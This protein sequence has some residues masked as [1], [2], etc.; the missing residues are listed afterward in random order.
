MTGSLPRD[1]VEFN[2]KVGLVIE[3]SIQKG[4]ECVWLKV[5]SA[6]FD[7][8][9]YLVNSLGFRVHHGD[10]GYVMVIKDLR[11]S[12][13][14]ESLNENY[15]PFASHF[16]ASGG[17]VVN[18]KNEVLFVKEKSGRRSKTWGFPGGRIDKGETM[19]EAATREI[20]E[21]TGLICEA[22]DMF[23]LRELEKFVFNRPDLYCLFLLRPVSE[24]Q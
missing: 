4:S 10:R 24:N 23:I 12:E 18:S 13:R 3:E 20:R 9:D 5:E 2:S 16:A 8:L 22:K 19:H 11:E 6:D 1:K 14:K 15:M 21:E 17:I 7:K